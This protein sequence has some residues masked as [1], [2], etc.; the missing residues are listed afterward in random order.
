MRR[1]SIFASSF[2]LDFCCK[3]ERLT[4]IIDRSNFQR[5]S[6]AGHL[7]A[8]LFCNGDSLE[9]VEEDSLEEEGGGAAVDGANAATVDAL[10][11]SN[12]AIGEEAT[13]AAAEVAAGATIAQKQHSH[14]SIKQKLR[15][16]AERH[17][18]ARATIADE[19][20]SFAGE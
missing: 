2:T 1:T 3:I 12:G 11:T 16:A 19:C 14:T 5:F 10:P 7:I 20:V 13:A 15:A 4:I 9:H 17:T 8:I 6:I 18:E